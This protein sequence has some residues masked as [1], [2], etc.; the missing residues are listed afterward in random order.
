MEKEG[1]YEVGYE[2]ESL[3]MFSMSTHN[4]SRVS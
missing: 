3:S 1:H 2:E 4:Y